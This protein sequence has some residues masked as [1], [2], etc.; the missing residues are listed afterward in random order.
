MRQASASDAHAPA[1]PAARHGFA[2]PPKTLRAALLLAAA[3]FCATIAPAQAREPLRD[4]AAF[5]RWVVENLGCSDDFMEQVQDRAFLDRAKALGVTVKTEWQEGDTPEGEFV[6]P[7]PILFGGKPATRIVYWG[8]SGAEF[9]AVLTAPPDVITQALKTRP[10][11][12]KLRKDFDDNIVGLRF[13]RAATHDER[14]APAVFV[15]RTEDAGASEAGCRF[16]D[17]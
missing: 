6:L 4:L 17:G 9:Y 2:V 15:R 16:F 3:A 1:L 14:L 10:V 5:Q 13:T 12:A 8:D 11:P 7:T